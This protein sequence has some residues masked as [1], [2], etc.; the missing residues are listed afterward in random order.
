M[1]IKEILA[2]ILLAVSLCALVTCTDGNEFHATQEQSIPEQT[3]PVTDQD[4]TD[5]QTESE[6]ETDSLPKESTAQSDQPDEGN[7]PIELPII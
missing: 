2:G 6:D 3:T 5:A 4:Q 1:W 7:L